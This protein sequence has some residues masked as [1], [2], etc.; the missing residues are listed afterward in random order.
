MNNIFKDDIFQKDAKPLFI[1]GVPR[2]GT[3]FLHQIMNSHPQICLTDEL[4]VV[5]WLFSECKKLREGFRIHGDPYPFNH[6]EEFAEYLYRNAGT[7]IRPFYMKLAIKWGKRNIKYWGDKYPHYDV[8]LEKI[9]EAFPRV[10][11][12]FIHR[13]LKDTLCSVM[14]GHKWS[15]EKSAKYV[16][17]IYSSYITKVEKLIKER[18]LTSDRFIHIKYENL[19]NNTWDIVEKIFQ[20]LGLETDSNLREK[21]NELRNIQSHSIRKNYAKKIYYDP[22]K[23]SVG[24]WKKQL[25]GEALEKVENILKKYTFIYEKAERMLEET[26]ERL[27]IKVMEK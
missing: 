9:P 20:Y 16:V 4:R 14:N 2:S 5:A 7:L 18:K 19:V 12:L 3:T 6:G 24:R 17:N 27:N 15:A 1:I 11:F 8:F 25:K 26:K 10:I 23:T 13:D 22:L 21:I